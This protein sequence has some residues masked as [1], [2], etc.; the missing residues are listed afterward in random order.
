MTKRK[1]FAP[2]PPLRAN[3]KFLLKCVGSRRE[4]EPARTLPHSICAS[5]VICNVLIIASPHFPP[6]AT[7]TF[8]KVWL[9]GPFNRERACVD[10]WR[11]YTW[12]LL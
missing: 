2:S 12:H 6:P 4:A 1:T 5:Q 9:G 10:W 7:R 3:R 8:T 11:A